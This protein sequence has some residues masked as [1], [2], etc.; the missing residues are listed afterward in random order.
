M[1]KVFNTI[2][3]LADIQSHLVNNNLDEY[4]FLHEL[5]DFLDQYEGNHEKLIAEHRQLVAYEKEVLAETISAIR[6][7]H[8]ERKHSARHRAQQQIKPLHD[9]CENLFPPNSKAVPMLIDWY[10]NLV[11][12][13]RIWA[14]Q[15]SA[16]AYGVMISVNSRR[17]TYNKRRRYK[18][19]NLDFDKAV[20][21]SV[22]KPLRS[23]E[24]KRA[25]ILQVQTSIYGALGEHRVVE[26][27][28]TLPD[29]FILI[30]DFVHVFRRALFDRFRGN[31]VRSVQI[32]HILVG[33]SGIFLIETKNWSR[34]TIESQVLRSPVEQIM[35]ANFALYRILKA[36]RAP[37]LSFKRHPW[38]NREFPIRNIVVF[39]NTKPSG[40]YEFVRMLHLNE[41]LPYINYFKPIFTNEEVEKVAQYL[42][43]MSQRK[44]V[45][46]RLGV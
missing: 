39:T 45:F 33:P 18:Y 22:S 4:D 25:A 31:Y 17:M 23:L 46:S 30:N 19:I 21:K 26:L 12:W 38:G 6:D 2:G 24:W 5:T 42:L 14:I 35:R 3:S 41:L 20:A 32:D 8:L 7:S 43:S 44:S 27:L 16:A 11:I 36:S 1:C 29:D 34:H 9:K 15:S 37:F 28:K 13:M 40:E 10:K